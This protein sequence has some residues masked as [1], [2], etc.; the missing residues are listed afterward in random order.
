MKK[1][2]IIVCLVLLLVFQLCACGNVRG[3]Y[4]R[5]DPAATERMPDTEDGYIENGKA[6]DGVVE[7]TLPIVTPAPSGK[8]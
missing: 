5:N 8:R 7:E 2:L 6:E 3:S 1:R 4:G